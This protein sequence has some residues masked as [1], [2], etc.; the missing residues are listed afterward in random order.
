[1]SK[2]VT[3]KLIDIYFY[4]LPKNTEFIL[5]Y[6]SNILYNSTLN[7]LCGTAS[8]LCVSLKYFLTECRLLSQHQILRIS[9]GS[10]YTIH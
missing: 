7:T 6:F 10:T 5:I 2:E 9:K 4:I 8:K 1:M 3:Y